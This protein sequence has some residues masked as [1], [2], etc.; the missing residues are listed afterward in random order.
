MSSRRSR[1][2][3][4]S[5]TAGTDPMAEVP[6]RPGGGPVR[7][8]FDKVE[9]RVG[10]PL[11]QLVATATFTEVLVRGFRW[12]LAVGRLV[13]HATRTAWHLVNLP[14]RSDL[15]W[16]SRQIASLENDVRMLSESQRAEGRRHDP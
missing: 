3:G 15:A 8:A 14:T 2:A 7:Q 10:V 12:Q 16:V 1:P 4:W 13:E 11:E 5:T 9:R 6:A